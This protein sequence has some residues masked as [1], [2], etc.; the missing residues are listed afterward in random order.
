MSSSYHPET[1]GASE[2][3]NKTVNQAIRYHIC[4]NQQ[5]WVAALPRICFN[6]MNTINSSSGFS[7]FHLRLGRSP[8]IIP[9]IVPSLLEPN[10]KDTPEALHVESIITKLVSDMNEAKY[11]LL[12]A[13]VFQTHFANKSRRADFNFAICDKFMLLTLHCHQE[14]ETKGDG[15]AANFFPCFDGPYIIINA[16][17][18]TSNYTL[19]L[20]NSPNIFPMFHSSE[21][22]PFFHNDT[23]LFPSPELAEPQPII[24]PQGLEEYLIDEII[25]SQR[26]GC[27]HQ[28]LIWWTGYGPEHDHWMSGAS[29]DNCKALDRWLDIEDQPASQ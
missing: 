18:E 2:R 3:S 29:L 12:Q 16:H 13:K 14:Y 1:D 4:R 7:G 19:E 24:T 6:M 28:Y 26:R 20:P 9:P 11:N 17:P 8:L 27:G 10:L 5:G 23:S 21:L 22:K 25:D 15:C